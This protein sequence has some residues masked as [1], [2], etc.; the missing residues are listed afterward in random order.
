MAYIG[1]NVIE[2]LTTAMYENLKIIFREY[3]QNSADAIDK[4]MAEGILQAKDAEI[5]INIEPQKRKI[6][7]E[8]NGYGIP[9]ADFKRIM[10]SIADSQKSVNNNKGFRGIG[11]L[12][13]ISVCDELRFIT[14][15]VGEAVESV[16]IWNA[17]L[18]KEILA[19]QDNKIDAA[20][21]VDQATTYKENAA[22]FREHYFRVEL[23]NIGSNAEDLLNVEKVSDYISAI[24]PVPYRNFCYKEKIK[25]FAKENG[26]SIDEY[27]VFINQDQIYK[28]YVTDLYEAKNGGKKSKY[29]SINDVK[30][31]IF[32]DDNDEPIAWMWYGIS[33]F[34]KQIPVINKMRAI[35]LR[36]GNIQI[37]DEQ[38][39]TTHQFFK[40]GRGSYYFVGEV[41]AISPL[42][43]PNAR[44]DYFNVNDECCLF[45]E[46]LS[47]L[48]YDTFCSLYHKAN[49]IK[50][51]LQ[52]ILE[53]QEEKAE[54][55]Q[56][57]EK[58]Q[59]IDEASKNKAAADLEE[60]KE[61]AA[62]AEATINRQK[63]K[64]EQDSVLSKVYEKLSE[65]YSL[66]NTKI[67]EEVCQTASG[68]YESS[69]SEANEVGE[70]SKKKQTYLTQSLTKYSKKEQK[71]VSRI[72]NT[73]QSILPPDQA[74]CVIEK[75]QEDL[76]K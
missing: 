70:R 27:R 68:R 61:K 21:L 74:S 56:K 47:S 52:H 75:I 49:E 35:R 2:N 59:F 4:A 45:E 22:D 32:T 51:N 33:N 65:K 30:F 9:K 73:I 54:F 1:K 13:G 19:D 38:T 42:L 20:S 17:K 39:L 12:G 46:R 62:K 36:K 60:K 16:C 41:F 63:E 28:P 55:E 15:A 10:E 18:I 5:H 50:K 72:Y 58:G 71:L 3:I 57:L 44:R 40:E 25:A 8:D 24:A 23:I 67:A 48:T 37:G 34:E 43:I 26:F 14:S 11:R 31:E 7:V 6:T 53:Y 29:D 76:M 66:P 64:Y 69:V